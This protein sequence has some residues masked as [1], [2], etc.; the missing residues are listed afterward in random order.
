MNQEAKNFEEAN[1]PEGRYANEFKVGYNFFEF[2]LDFGQSYGEDRPAKYHTRVITN[3]VYA[4]VL[5]KLLNESV[6]Q[7]EHNFG[8]IIDRESG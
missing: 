3:P 7:Y 5:L 8:G 4:K 6:N 2:V 1:Q